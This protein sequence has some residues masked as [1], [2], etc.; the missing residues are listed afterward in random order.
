MTLCGCGWFV[1]HNESFKMT[2]RSSRKIVKWGG[3]YLTLTFWRFY[4]CSCSSQSMKWR[5]DSVSFRLILPYTHSSMALSSGRISRFARSRFGGLWKIQH[6]KSSALGCAYRFLFVCYGV[7]TKE[8]WRYIIPSRKDSASICV[9]SQERS[10]RPTNSRDW[11]SSVALLGVRR[12]LFLDESIRTA[13]R[14]Q[15]CL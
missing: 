4:Y 5:Y 6:S 12:K 3:Y 13:V 7:V 2:R 15:H 8:L 10:Q 14:R 9:V 11:V 1:Q